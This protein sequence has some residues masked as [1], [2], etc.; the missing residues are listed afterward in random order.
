[1][2]DRRFIHGLKDSAPCTL[3]SQEVETL[4][5]LLGC[6]FSHDVWFQVPR[7]Y[8]WQLHAPAA[9]DRFVLWWLKVRKL[10]SKA[11]RKSFDSLVLMVVRTIWLERNAR[12][13]RCEV[14]SVSAVVAC[15]WDR[16]EL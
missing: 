3:C 6:M 8:G 16:C 14:V 11:R 7:R 1:M 9:G 13:F 2:T 5:H 12:V 15:I 10:V 4:D